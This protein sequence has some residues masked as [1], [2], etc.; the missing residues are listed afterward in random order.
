M[1]GAHTTVFCLLNPFVIYTVHDNVN[2]INVLEMIADCTAAGFARSGKVRPIT[3]DKDVLYKAFE[4][5]C[6]MVLGMC[7]LKN[8]ID[9]L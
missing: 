5:T 3:I 8:F 7:E 1:D 2:L 9:S 6:K 4:N